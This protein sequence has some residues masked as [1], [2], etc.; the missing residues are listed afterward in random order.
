M[1]EVADKDLNMAPLQAEF[2]LYAIRNPETMETLSRQLQGPRKTL[3][4]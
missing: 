4:H 1:V 2:W 3:E